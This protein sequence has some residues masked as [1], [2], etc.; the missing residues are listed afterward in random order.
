MDLTT[1]QITEFGLSEEQVGKINTWSGETVADTKKEYDGK[2]NTDAEAILTGASTKI[3]ETTKVERKQGEKIGDYIP[4]AWGEF[5]T[6]KLSE[7]QTAKTEYEDKV[8]NFKGDEAKDSK[9]SEL[10]TEMDSFK[11]KY[12]NYDEL[13]IKADKFDP[14]SEK[15]EANKKQVAFNSVKPSFPKEANEYEVSAKWNEFKKSV[16]EKYNLEIVDGEAKA[17]DKENIH[18]IVK[19]SELVK[20][21]E[22]LTKL[23]EGRKQGGPGAKTIPKVDIEGVPFKVPEGSEKDSEIRT[24]AVRD[25][26]ITQ[27]INPTSDEWAKKFKEYNNA[28]INKK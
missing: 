17:I 1:E 11:Q 2:A 14:L 9:I 13:K 19:L 5:N 8:R 26:L 22:E 4:R 10:E 18:K 15:Y 3:L 27:E 6:V 16:L 28:I 20:K 12:A 24:K 23:L 7:V 21:D 25:Y